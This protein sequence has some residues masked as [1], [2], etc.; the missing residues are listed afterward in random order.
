MSRIIAEILDVPVI[1]YNHIIKAW[2]KRTGA[3]GRDLA[4]L[5][6][7]RRAVITGVNHLGLDPT[8][9]ISG[10][11]YFA[12]QE[13]A[14]GDNEW[15]ARRLGINTEDKPEAVFEK[16]ITWSLSHAQT[17]NVWVCKPAVIKALLIKQPPKTVMKTLGLRSAD[18]MIKRNHP[19]ELLALAAQLESPEWNKKFRLHYKR[20]VP[21]DFDESSINIIIMSPERIKKL[22]AS[23]SYISQFI[24]L[25]YEL[26][27]MIL[28]PP[29]YRYPLDVLA[30]CSLIFE[31][32]MELRRFAT[33]LR[34][35]S[36]RSDF[37]EKIS[38]VSRDGVIHGTQG[39]QEIGW[40]S[41][42]RHLVGNDYFLQKIDQPFTAPDDL[43]ASSAVQ[44][45]TDYNERFAYWQPLE[46]GFF[47]EPSKPHVSMNLID[48]VL[49]AANRTAYVKGHKVHGQNKLWEE[50]WARYLTEDHVAEHIV[51]HFMES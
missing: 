29:A 36:M 27:S 21:S 9:T 39:Y 33:Y 38:S 48:V 5:A 16:I 25:N 41:I 46:H 15:L 51:N 8:D 4:M 30:S 50:L 11:L 24:S 26:G 34:M 43:S 3:Q 17:D 35:I 13:R 49:N 22:A 2:E 42:H 18:S 6:E 45:L 32:I 7:M 44:V 10:E 40:N 37:G 28:C 19:A 1:R 47:T 20:L 31:K 14:R 23:T 12:L